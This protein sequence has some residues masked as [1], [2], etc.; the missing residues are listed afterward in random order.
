MFVVTR[1]SGSAFF[2]WHR[3]SSLCPLSYLAH[4]LES[5]CHK[6]KGRR[7][8]ARPTEAGHYE[9]GH[10]PKQYKNLSERMNSFPSAATGVA[11]KM[12]PSGRSL[13][14]SNSNCGFAA[15]TNVFPSRDT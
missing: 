15:T 8:A 10:F 5:L 4:R 11:W 7:C 1:F 2:L 13:V 12:L 3:L 9:R 14:A 6:T